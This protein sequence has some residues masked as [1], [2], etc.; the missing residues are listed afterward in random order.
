MH[1]SVADDDQAVQIEKYL[2][3]VWSR[4]DMLAGAERQRRIRASVDL[5]NSMSRLKDKVAVISG[6][7]SDIGLA[8]AGR[9]VQEGAHVF[10]FGRRRD[11]LKERCA[12]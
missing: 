12:S 4:S 2:L 1:E 10:I 7:T 3:T 5:R 6:G 8:I 9:F 11:A